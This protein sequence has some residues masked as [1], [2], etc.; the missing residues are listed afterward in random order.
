MCFH[1]KQSKKAQQVEHKFKAKVKDIESLESSNHFNGFTFPKTPI[2]TNEDAS[3]IQLVNWGLLP[4]WAQANFDKKNTLNARSE[5]LHEKKSFKNILN[6]RCLII[7]DGFYEWQHQGSK[8][9]RYEIG[10]NNELF[11][12]AGL[13]DINNGNKS[14]TILTKEAEGIMRTI[15]NSKL[16]MPIA[17]FNESEMNSWLF[18]N[19]LNARFDFTS[20][21]PLQATLF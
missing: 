17:L 6:N 1:S 19:E 18:D 16:R 4:Y 7:V 8:C 13:F 2:I 15:H 20:N 12:L 9:L 5:T 10:N 14:Y 21:P 11:A 3:E